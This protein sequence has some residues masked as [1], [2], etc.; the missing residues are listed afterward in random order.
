VIPTTSP[1]S[2]ELIGEPTGMQLVTAHKGI[3][4]M[5]TRVRGK[6]GHSS[7]PDVGASAI[8]FA[9]RFI[10]GIDAVLPKE[11]NEAFNPPVTT[12]NIGVIGGGEA[13]NIIPELCELHWEFRHLPDQDPAQIHASLDRK[14]REVKTRMRGISVQTRVDAA[15][16]AMLAG[17]NRQVVK[18]LER[19]LQPPEPRVTTAPFVTEGGI[20]QQAG[21]PAVICG[22]G[23][24]EQAHQPDENVSL[25]AMDDY[26]AFLSRLMADTYP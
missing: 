19:F 1:T 23:L 2:W 7:R 15:V 26:R 9:A 11:R 20:Y 21:I 10:S 14:S 25:R 6:P 17:E 8:Q 5:V 22:P 4:Q 18:E 24:L 16:P 3:Q 12:F 13:V